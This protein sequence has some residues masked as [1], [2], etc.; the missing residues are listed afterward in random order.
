M[1]VLDALDRATASAGG[2]AA[3]PLRRPAR[4][5]IDPMRIIL[6]LD[7][8]HQRE[9]VPGARAATAEQMRLLERE[10]LRCSGLDIAQASLLLNGL[11]WRRGRS[12]S[13]PLQSLALYSL[14]FDPECSQQEALRRLAQFG[15]TASA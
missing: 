14:G 4:V 2:G 3:T 10:G 1:S 9:A 13:S 12:L 15:V 8:M 11:R 7:G 6:S 5:A